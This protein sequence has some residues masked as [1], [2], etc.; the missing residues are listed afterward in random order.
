MHPDWL[1]PL[2]E[3]I[4][5]QLLNPQGVLEE[6][7]LDRVAFLH[8]LKTKLSSDPDDG[9][10][11]TWGRWFLADPSARIVSPFSTVTLP[12]YVQSMIEEHTSG[13][14]DEAEGLAHGN[15]QI[16]GRI[17]EARALLNPAKT[18]KP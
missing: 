6:T 13:S 14:L 17:S 8:R 7:K 9:L 10:W 2:T 15:E 18:K 11:G 5:G 1:L 3:A 12:Q 16:L 4:G